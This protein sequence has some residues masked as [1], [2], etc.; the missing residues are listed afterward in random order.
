MGDTQLV[1]RSALRL[2]A[3]GSD[4][5]KLEPVFTDLIGTHSKRMDILGLTA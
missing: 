5:S 4:E 2:S 1:A 3:D